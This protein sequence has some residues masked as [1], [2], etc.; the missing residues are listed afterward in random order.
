MVLANCNLTDRWRLFGRWSFLN[1]G[2]G[3][4]TGIVQR[5]HE[6]SCGVAFEVYHD[7]E[8]RGEYRHDFSRGTDDVDTVSIHFSFGI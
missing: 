6:L 8:I 2:A 5:R 1:D 3:L 4:I 7:V